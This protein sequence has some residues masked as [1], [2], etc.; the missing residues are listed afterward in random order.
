MPNENTPSKK[1]T[2]KKPRSSQEQYAQLGDNDLGALRNLLHGPSAL[3]ETI[4]SQNT[5]VTT[6]TLRIHERSTESFKQN[7][8]NSRETWLKIY[9]ATSTSE[10]DKRAILNHLAQLDEENAKRAKDD[11]EFLKQ[12]HGAD[13]ER[14]ETAFISALTLLGLIVSVYGIAP[15]LLSHSAKKLHVLVK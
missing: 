9:N 12:I 3:L 13:Q 4:V 6:E 11:K 2:T 10:E 1:P 14:K 7:Q 15:Q 5:E 8:T